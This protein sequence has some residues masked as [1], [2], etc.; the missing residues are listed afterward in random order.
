LNQSREALARDCLARIELAMGPNVA[1][2]PWSR[3]LS[4]WCDALVILSEE[5]AA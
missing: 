3:R 2:W 5:R 4:L 1:R